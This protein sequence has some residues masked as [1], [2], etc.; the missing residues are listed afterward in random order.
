MKSIT[1]VLM[2]GPVFLNLS[3]RAVDFLVRSSLADRT[4][5][6]GCTARCCHRV[7]GQRL[8][9]ELLPTQ[10]LLNSAAPG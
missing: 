10:P 7:D 8:L 4:P 3:G 9:G 5:L 2:L 1:S 6:S